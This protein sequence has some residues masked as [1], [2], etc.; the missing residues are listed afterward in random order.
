MAE[1]ECTQCAL[2]CK[3]LGRALSQEYPEWMQ[4]TVD[5]FPYKAKEN[6]HCEMLV[7]DHCS[8][9]ENRP[10]MCDIN[11]AAE[12]LDMEMSKD[13]WFD[14]NTEACKQLQMEII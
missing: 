13:E 14:M 1:F 4:P 9:Y 6:G 5:A 8:V 11:R 7:D 10:L 12:E 3:N 2:C